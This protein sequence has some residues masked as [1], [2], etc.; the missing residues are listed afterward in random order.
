M[1]RRFATIVLLTGVFASP[2]AAQGTELMPGVTYERAVEFTPRGAVV[3]H[4]VT[5]P[6]PGGL[7]Q[8]GPV[9]ARAT[10]TGGTERLTQIEKDASAQATVVGINGDFST[11]PDS[12]PS[13]I[14]LSGGVLTHPPLA[15]RSSIGVDAAGTLHIERVKFFGTWRGTGQRRPLDGLNQSPAQGQVVLLTP[16][17]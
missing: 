1:L 7:Y 2:A 10:V 3:L 9:V 5:A 6:R 8:L 16:A 17:Y 12:R 14:V 15:T 11:G 13:G 4:V